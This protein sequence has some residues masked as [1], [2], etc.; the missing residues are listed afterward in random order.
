MI[1]L[2]NDLRRENCGLVC[3]YYFFMIGILKM[4][5]TVDNNSLISTFLRK[6]TST[7]K[8]KTN[9][10]RLVG[11]RDR[12]VAVPRDRLRGLNVSWHRLL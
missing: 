12:A 8:L 11:N 2:T 1:Y 10:K 7:I 9:A 3:F 4:R 6:W 5:F